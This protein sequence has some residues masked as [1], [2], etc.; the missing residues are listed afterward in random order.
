MRWALVPLF[1]LSAACGSSNDPASTASRA[2]TAK[3]STTPSVLDQDVKRA[4]VLQS[5]IERADRELA[6]LEAAQPR[7]EGAIAQKKKVLLAL[8]TTLTETQARI[9]R[10][11]QR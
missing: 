7:D 2:R 10:V 3:P 9:D 8:H 1:V 6:Q 5:A 4:L 11:T